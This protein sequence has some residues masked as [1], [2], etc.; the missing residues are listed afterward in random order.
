MF[1]LWVGN[2]STRW[3]SGDDFT[4]PEEL[5]PLLERIQKT[6]VDK[7]RQEADGI[8]A[9]A[10]KEAAALVAEAEKRAAAISSEAE[11]GADAFERR[12]KTSLRQAARDVVLSVG[13]A[14]SATLRRVAQRQTKAAMDPALLR[15]M[16]GRFV[17]T[18][19]EK[20]PDA[21][22][23]ELLVSPEDHEAATAF[24][25]SMFAEQLRDGIEIKADSG[26]A[27]GFK[28][29]LVDRHVQHDFTAEA[30]TEAICTLLRPKLADIVREGMAA[31]TSAS[32]E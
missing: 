1:F 20:G 9:E 23:I 29:T 3:T 17:E 5:Q 27:A 7:A 22:R 19:C 18:Y 24:V 16:L 31:E 11:K 10:R 30:A 12:A 2:R 26:I 15:Q 6:A 32:E 25:L 8:L 13:E 4:M 14:I 28:A 21:S